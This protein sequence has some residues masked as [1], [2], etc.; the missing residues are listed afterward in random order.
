[1]KF[2][3]KSLAKDNA[4]MLDMLMSEFETLAKIDSPSVMK[5]FDVYED[6][7]KFYIVS[8]LMQGV[9][10]IDHFSKMAQEEF[11]EKLV[12]S[13]MKQILSGLC[14]CHSK[15]I[16][17]RDIKPENIMFAD[18]EQKILKLI[19]FGFAKIF[20]PQ[21][22]KVQEILGSP[23]YMAPEICAKKP[24]DEKCDIWSCGILSYL[25]LSGEVPYVMEADT[26]LTTLLEQI[27]AKHFT[28]DTFKTEAWE[29]ISMEAKKFALRMLEKDPMKRASAMDLLNDPWLLQAKDTPLDKA[30]SK[31]YLDNMKNNVVSSLLNR[32]Q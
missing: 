31:K 22:R 29:H 18:K 14:H 10:L 3:K 32:V 23:M 25:L 16:A 5:V 28:M 12:A 30:A 8:E 15:K 6:E 24:Y 9:T 11:T 21:E 26:S 27:L 20:N 13:Y 1:M 7:H 2:V 17:H 4:K 19:D